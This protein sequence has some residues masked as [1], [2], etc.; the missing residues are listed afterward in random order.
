MTLRLLGICLPNA[1]APLISSQ[2][3]QTMCPSKEN[4]ILIADFLLGK[5]S[6]LSVAVDTI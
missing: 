2:H 5:V 6:G 4:V 3:V 1:I